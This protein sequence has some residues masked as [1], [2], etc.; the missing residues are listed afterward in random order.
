MGEVQNGRDAQRAVEMNVEV[1]LGEA[2]NGL[3]R[4]SS[5]GGML[6]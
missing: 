4:K 6:Q 5:H 3:E 1:G 2:L